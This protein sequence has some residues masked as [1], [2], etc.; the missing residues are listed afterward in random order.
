[1]RERRTRQWCEGEE[2][3]EQEEQLRLATHKGA[4]GDVVMRE[5]RTESEAARESERRAEGE[6]RGRGERALERTEELLRGA[7][8]REHVL[9]QP[10]QRLRATHVFQ[11]PPRALGHEHV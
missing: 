3:G 2:Q 5:S 8:L 11:Q 10:L 7:V 4:H 6:V 1:M 9:K